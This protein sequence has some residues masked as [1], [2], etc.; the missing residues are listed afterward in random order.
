MPQNPGKWQKQKVSTQTAF[1]KE[2]A[3]LH[4]AESG[5]RNKSRDK[6]ESYRL[7]HISISRG[8][9]FQYPKAKGRNR[10]MRTAYFEEAVD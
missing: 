4:I 6:V 9:V 2:V 10:A 7:P 8:C 1:A 3:L 5:S